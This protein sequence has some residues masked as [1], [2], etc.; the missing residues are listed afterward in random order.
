MSGDAWLAVAVLAP[1]ALYGV[2][3]LWRDWCAAW[4]NV[5]RL[6][7]ADT[8]AEDSPEWGQR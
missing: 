5:D 2:A 8:P 7:D 3:A 1:P 4:R 6:A